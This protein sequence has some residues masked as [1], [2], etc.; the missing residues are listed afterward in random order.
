MFKGLDDLTIYTSSI[1]IIDFFS[2][3]T[4][5]ILLEWQNLGRIV[6]YN[7]TMLAKKDD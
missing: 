1:V 6:G 7:D 5:Y 3:F 4:S 2:P